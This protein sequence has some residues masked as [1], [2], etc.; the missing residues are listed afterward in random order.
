M[1]RY[2]AA[3]SHS[4][5]T[6]FRDLQEPLLGK[7]A[8]RALRVLGTGAHWSGD[9]SSFWPHEVGG[10]TSFLRIRTPRAV[11]AG[12]KLVRIGRLAAGRAG[13][14][15]GWFQ[16]YLVAAGFERVAGEVAGC[17]RVMHTVQGNRGP[18]TCPERGGQCKGHHPVDRDTVVLRGGFLFRRK[19]ESNRRPAPNAGPC[20]WCVPSEGS[21]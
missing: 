20:R 16:G 12:S 6:T 4:R 19:H 5:F 17:T 15:C 8:G 7:S 2:T 13:T 14:G 11:G 1:I 9:R 3:D 21:I 18:P 10:A